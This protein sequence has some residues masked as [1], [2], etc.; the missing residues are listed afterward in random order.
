MIHVVVWKGE[1]K[2]IVGRILECPL[3]RFPTLISGL[4]MWWDNH[5]YDYVTL[6]GKRD[7]ADVFKVPL[8]IGRL[9][10]LIPIALI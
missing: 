8:K 3:P 6:P 1:N 10:C 7:F 4:W 5:A 9:F 2:S